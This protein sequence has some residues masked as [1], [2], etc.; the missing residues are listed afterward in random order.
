VNIDVFNPPVGELGDGAFSRRRTRIY[1]TSLISTS[2]T[3]G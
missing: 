3:A 1:F 2:P